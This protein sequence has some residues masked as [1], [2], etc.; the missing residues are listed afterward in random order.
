MTRPSHA[1]PARTSGACRSCSRSAFMVVIGSISAAVL[2]SVASGLNAA[3][4]TRS[5]AQSRVRGRR[6][7][8]LRHRSGARGPVATWDQGSPPSVPTFLNSASSIGCGGPYSWTIGNVPSEAH[9]NGVDIR[10][11]CTPAP[12][13]DSCGLSPAQ[14]HLQCVS[15]YGRSLCAA[16]RSSACAGQLLRRAIGPGNRSVLERQLM[17]DLVSRLARRLR[18]RAN[19]GFTLIE[20]IITV[21]LLSM[22][23]AGHQRRARHGHEQLGIDERTRGRVER[24]AQLLAAFLTA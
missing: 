11:E 1:S 14:R 10:V 15:G 24:R 12:G 22:L 20:V 18:N 8:R 17:T 7:R 4:H 16:R 3:K 13:T 6:S 5:G 19:E 23:T 2:S 21:V 9:L